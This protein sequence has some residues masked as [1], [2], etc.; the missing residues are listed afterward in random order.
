MFTYIYIRKVWKDTYQ[1]VNCSI[2]E[3]GKERL[4]LLFIFMCCMNCCSEHALLFIIHMTEAK[5]VNGE[6]L[7]SC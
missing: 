1:T 6:G 7:L 4:V 5:S 3:K 2:W